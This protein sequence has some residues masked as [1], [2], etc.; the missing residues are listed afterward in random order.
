MTQKQILSLLTSTI[1]KATFKRLRPSIQQRSYKRKDGNEIFLHIPAFI[2][3][4]VDSKFEVIDFG[5]TYH[6]KNSKVC[7]TVFKEPH[8]T[9]HVTVY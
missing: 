8:V 7:V 4:D 5:L 3:L 1:D 9:S 6:I 2:N